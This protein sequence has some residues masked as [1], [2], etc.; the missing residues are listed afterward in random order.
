MKRKSNW[1]DLF[2]KQKLDLTKYLST[3]IIF[4]YILALK[5]IKQ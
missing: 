3:N 4:Y 5:F 1:L 2:T